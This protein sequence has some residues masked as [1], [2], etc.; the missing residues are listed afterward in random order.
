MSRVACWQQSPNLG[1]ASRRCSLTLL[2][3]SKGGLLLHYVEQIVGDLQPCLAACLDNLFAHSL[4]Q[5]VAERGPRHTPHVI[6]L[7][8]V[9][10]DLHSGAGGDQV[11]HAVGGPSCN[12]WRRPH[13]VNDAV[14]AQLL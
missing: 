3:C 10:E 12:W 8:G 4:A 1:N 9:H 13:Q 5:T 2:R 14:R 6:N 7:A 11:H